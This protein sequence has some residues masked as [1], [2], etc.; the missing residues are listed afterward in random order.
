MT[1]EVAENEV[2]DRWLNIVEDSMGCEMRLDPSLTEEYPWGWRVCLIPMRPGECLQL[3]EL[4]EFAC[5]RIIG[6][7]TPVGTKGLAHVLQLWGLWG[8]TPP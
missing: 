5:R 2:L 7:S 4:Q 6:D 3:F 1:R 8:L